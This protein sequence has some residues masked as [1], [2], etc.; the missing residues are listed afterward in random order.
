MVSIMIAN[1]SAM[2][3]GYTLGLSGYSQRNECVSAITNKNLALLT[4]VQSPFNLHRPAVVPHEVLRR[5][6]PREWNPSLSLTLNPALSLTVHKPALSLSFKQL[7]PSLA[8]TSL[9]A[10][11]MRYF[12]M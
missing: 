7:K 11:S 5:T 10:M 6:A 8:R 1:P 2:S 3:S 12:A 4:R 9:S